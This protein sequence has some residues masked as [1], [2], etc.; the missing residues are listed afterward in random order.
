MAP[1]RPLTLNPGPLSSPSHQDIAAVV[2][3]VGKLDRN[4]R[5][6][7]LPWSEMIPII[8]AALGDVGGVVGLIAEVDDGNDYKP[9]YLLHAMAVYVCR[10]GMEKQRATYLRALEAAIAGAPPASVKGY[11]VRQLQVA[12]DASCINP[13]GALLLDPELYE[14]AAQA[15]LAIGGSA[16]EF[17]AALPKASGGPRLTI[18]QALGVLRDAASV[19]ALTAA[20]RDESQDVRLAAVWGLANIGTGKDDVL[21]ALDRETGFARIRMVDACHTLIEQ[22]KGAG[23]AT[24]IV[25]AEQ[26]RL[27][28]ER[29]QVGQ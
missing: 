19:E 4:G 26:L 23:G 14:Y 6:D 18:V 7:G 9:R 16:A 10:P 11:L 12:G 24:N 2:D 22:L 8:D 17:R 3:R 20:A 25:R 29:R 13:L 5:L 1:V 27:L 15:L 21:E 28:L